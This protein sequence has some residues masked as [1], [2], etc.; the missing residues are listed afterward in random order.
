[1]YP[2]IVYPSIVFSLFIVVGGLVILLQPISRRLGNYLELLIE[3]RRREL[4]DQSIPAID[5]G[6]I[7]ALLEAMEQRLAHVEERQEFTDKLLAK[8]TERMEYPVRA[9]PLQSEPR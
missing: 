1:M 6:R 5:A 2:E 3:E 7:T 4:R 9:A 8:T